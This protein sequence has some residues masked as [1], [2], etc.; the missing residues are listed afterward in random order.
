MDLK[1]D[2]KDMLADIYVR[3][4]S[5]AIEAQE[6]RGQRLLITGSFLPTEINPVGGKEALEAFGVKFLGPLSDDALFQ[7]VQ[8]PP[9]WHLKP[10]K[11]AYWTELFDEKNRTRGA[12][13]Y[14]AAFYDRRAA[15]HVFCRYGI[16]VTYVRDFDINNPSAGRV[17]F[18]IDRGQAGRVLFR[19]NDVDLDP[20]MHERTCTAWLDEHFPD[21]RSPVAYW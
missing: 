11:S 1:E 9:G 7:H 6:A 3:G 19:L 20:S 2:P 8:F 13:F 4:T 17:T 15:L 5:G 10:Q 21:W 18:I 12:I 14:K 16:D